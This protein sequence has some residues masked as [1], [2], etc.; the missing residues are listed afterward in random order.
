MTVGTGVMALSLQKRELIFSRKDIYSLLF[1]LFWSVNHI[2]KFTKSMENRSCFRCLVKCFISSTEIEWHANCFVNSEWK[3]RTTCCPH[4]VKASVSTIS[5]EIPFQFDKKYSVKI[6][7][8]TVMIFIEIE[9]GDLIVISCFK[10][11]VFVN[12]NHW[13]WFAMRAMVAPPI[14]AQNHPAPPPIGQPLNY[15]K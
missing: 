7:S 3:W 14:S 11:A 9:S 2:R 6:Q 8:F 15:N 4:T 5:K 1:L 13:S 12:C 10:F